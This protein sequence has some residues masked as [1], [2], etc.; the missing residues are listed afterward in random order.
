LTRSI[1][2]GATA[3]PRLFIAIDCFTWS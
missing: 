1:A 2:R 3:D